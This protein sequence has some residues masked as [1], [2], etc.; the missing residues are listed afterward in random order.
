MSLHQHGTELLA[1]ATKSAPPAAVSG[2][3]LA[4]MSLNEWVLAAT[5]LYTALQI[6]L[7]VRR[8]VKGIKER[9]L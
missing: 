9:T 2:A 4:G 7:L 3:V 5:L 8:I 6:G 1:A